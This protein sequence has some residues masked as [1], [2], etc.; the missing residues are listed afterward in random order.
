[1][2][3]WIAKRLILTLPFFLFR[4][5]FL[6]GVISFLLLRKLST[7]DSSRNRAAAP[8]RGQGWSELA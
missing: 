7:R 5:S 2:I 4:R 3:N 6:G 8:R 1:M